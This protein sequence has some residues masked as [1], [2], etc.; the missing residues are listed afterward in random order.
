MSAI[1][2]NARGKPGGSGPF[3][4]QSVFILRH[5]REVAESSRRVSPAAAQSVYVALTEL[6]T[7]ARCASVQSPI[8]EVAKRAGLGYRTTASAL[9]LIEE[10]GFVQVQN[11]YFPGGELRTSNTYTLVS[12]DVALCK[13]CLA[14]G[15]SAK[16]QPLPRSLEDAEEL[17]EKRVPLSFDLVGWI[18]QAKQEFPTR[19]DIDAIAAKFST[20]Y[21][22]RPDRMC[23]QRLLDWVRTERAP[24]ELGPQKP[25]ASIPVKPEPPGWREIIAKSF[26][27]TE[28]PSRDHFEER[29]WAAISQYNRD[30]IT[31]QVSEQRSA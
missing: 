23:L 9:G 16:L 2:A 1:V 25:S 24:R 19:T 31:K 7:D 29:D 6:A 4:W 21:S 8:S 15:N 30:W 22:A 13:F 14:R 3:C 28:F 12:H 26:P 5:V 17:K 18:A 20:H 10:A 11:N 27:L